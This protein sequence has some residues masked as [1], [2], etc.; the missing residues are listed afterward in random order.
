MS[1]CL[2]SLPSSPHNS[3]PAT[4]LLCSTND[5]SRPGLF[6]GP[7]FPRPGLAL[8]LPPRMPRARFRFCLH[9]ASPGRPHFQHLPS[10]ATI[11]FAA[12]Q[13][14]ARLL[15][16]LLAGPRPAQ[17]LHPRHCALLCTFPR[18]PASPGPSPHSKLST[19]NHDR[20]SAR[21]LTALC[22][23]RPATEFLAPANACPPSASLLP[24][25]ASH[26]W[27]TLFTGPPM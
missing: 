19:A 1:D 10:L 9:P 26:P 3:F 6:S 22:R 24:R 21:C 27:C 18:P 12:L 2:C 13:V 11:L 14:F 8:A 15:P 23:L 25:H 17:P 7:A 16:C 4:S 20:C 5:R